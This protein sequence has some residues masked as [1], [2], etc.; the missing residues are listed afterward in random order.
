MVLSGQQ[1]KPDAGT[2][3]VQQERISWT[4]NDDGSVRQLWESSKDGGKSWAVVF[5][6]LY[7]RPAAR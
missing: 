2:G 1:L 7:R 3:L 5:D 4:P 6:R